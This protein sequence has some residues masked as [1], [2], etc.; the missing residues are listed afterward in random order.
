MTWSFPDRIDVLSG[1][2]HTQVKHGIYAFDG[3]EQRKIGITDIPKDRFAK[4]RRFG[5]K[6]I[7]VSQ[8]LG[9]VVAREQEQAFLK[10]LVARGLRNGRK[11]MHS[12]RED[13]YTETWD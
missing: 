2:D 10:V 6:P 11:R 1:K 7:E 4:V 9:G 3:C 13:G 12:T 8:A 5:W